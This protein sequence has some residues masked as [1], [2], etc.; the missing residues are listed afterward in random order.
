M[1][2]AIVLFLPS[3]LAANL[4]ADERLEGIA[5]RSVHLSFRDAPEGDAFYNEVTVKKSAEGTYFAVCGFNKGYFG[6]QELRRG[7]KVLIFSV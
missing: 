7:K 5:C 4:L 6:L 3:L 2:F 1:R